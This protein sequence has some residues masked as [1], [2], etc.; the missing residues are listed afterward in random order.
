MKIEITKST[1]LKEKISDE[2]KLGFG[3]YFTD[4]MFV[5]DY[6]EGQDWH[7]PRIIPYQPITVDPSCLTFHYGQTVF[8]GLKAYR[9]GDRIFLFR[10]E[11]NF[12][13]MNLSCDRYVFRVLM[14][15]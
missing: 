11:E 8:E 10:P 7:N 9:N 6:K 2:S 13:R 3:S 12:K 4:H 1:N 14:K 15:N 5:M